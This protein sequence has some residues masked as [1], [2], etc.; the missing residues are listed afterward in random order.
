MET[1]DLM[2]ILLDLRSRLAVAEHR[3]DQLEDYVRDKFDEP[4]RQRRQRMGFITSQEDHEDQ[5]R[6]K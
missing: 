4:S 5:G 6:D 3:I 2:D 1:E